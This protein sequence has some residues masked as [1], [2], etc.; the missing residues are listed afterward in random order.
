MAEHAVNI[1]EPAGIVA[2]F[3]NLLDT[4]LILVHTRL[5]LA[6]SHPFRRNKNSK[7]NGILG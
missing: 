7:I 6:E 4:G 3:R 1:V 2:I 5:K